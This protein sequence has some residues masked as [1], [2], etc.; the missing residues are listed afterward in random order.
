MKLLGQFVLWLSLAAGALSAAT[1]YLAS[2]DLPDRELVG[3]TLVAPAGQQRQPDGTS[4]PIAAPKSELTPEL[5]AELRHAGVKTVRVQHFS[6]QRWR[7]KWAFLAACA[8]LLLGGA[9]IRAG[10]RMQLALPAGVHVAGPRA[11]PEESL[12]A[13][14]TAL[15][16]LRSRI[17]QL[18]NARQ[19]LAA[20]LETVGQLQRTSMEA[21]IEARGTLTARLGLR[22]YA[23]LMDSY[24]AAERQ[25]HRAWS[26]AADEVLHES[27]T[28]LDRAAALVHETRQRLVQAP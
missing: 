9:L 6:L 7:G 20:I 10:A 18:P 16:E 26:A 25:L 24:A 19:Q 21:F 11:S 27:L 15:Q 23:E 17:S 22:R 12:Q 1:A 28:S 14:D 2:L 13:I 5:L 8:G 4:R 3:L